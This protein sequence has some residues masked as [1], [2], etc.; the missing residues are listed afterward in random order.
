VDKG[1]SPLVQALWQ[2]GFETLGSC[3][4]RPSGKAYVAFPI[5]RQGDEFHQMLEEVGV[6][7]TNEQ[8]TLRLKNAETDEIVEVDS[9][10]V[11]FSPDDIQRITTL[12]TKAKKTKEG[13]WSREEEGQMTT[14]LRHEPIHRC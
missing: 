10:N 7:A 13:V 9:A 2:R 8:K 3:Q 5:V 1:I 6:E 11:L 12:L 14:F 4:Q